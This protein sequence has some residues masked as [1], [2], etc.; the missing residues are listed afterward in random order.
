MVFQY[1]YYKRI[2]PNRL[3][4]AN[5]QGN[6]IGIL[7]GIKEF[8]LK[9]NVNSIDEISFKIYE[10][11]DGIRNNLYDKLEQMRQIKVQNIAI[12]QIKEINEVNN[13]NNGYKEIIC[14][15]LENELVGKYIDAIDG[16]YSLYDTSDQEY[17]I[18]HIVAKNCSW[19]IG[20]VSASLLLKYRTFSVDS[21]KIYN[22]LTSECSESFGC[23]FQFDTWNKVIN[24]ITLEELGE[25]TDIIISDKNILK[26]YV[27]KSNLDKIITSMRVRGGTNSDG[28][29]FD[30]RSVNPDGSSTLINVNYYKTT[31]W[32]SQSLIDALNVY[33]TAYDNYANQ[34]TTALNT[35]K[36]YQSDL[37]ILQTQLT[38]INSQISAQEQITGVSIKLHYGRP[39][40]NGESDY[41]TYI[42][43]INSISTLATQKVANETEIANKRNQILAI[44][45][46]LDNIGVSLDKSNYFTS[47]QLKELDGFITMGDEYS[48]ETYSAVDTMTEEEIIQM[49]LDLKTQAELELL[50][51]CRPQY[52]IDTSIS[53]L[54]TIQDN[55]DNIISYESWRDQLVCGN[56][57]SLRL[58]PDY[59]VQVRLMVIEYDFDNFE[60]VN[61]IFSDKN[62]LDDELTQLGE[63]ISQAQSSSK[64]F[65]AN[66]YSLLRAS[67][68]TSDLN[69]FRLGVI[70]ASLNQMKNDEKGEITF[71]EFGLKAKQLLPDGTYG[72]HMMW[73]N[74]FR[75]LFSDNSMQSAN[76]AFGLLSLPDGTQ[77]MGIATDL[78]FGKLIMSENLYIQNPSGTYTINNN[79]FTATSTIG[80]NTYSVGINPSTPSDIINVKV[81]GTKKFYI[82]TVTNE[83]MFNGKLTANAINADMINALNIVATSVKSSWVYAGNIS[84][85]QIT[86]GTL[87]GDRING[88][89]ITGVTISGSTLTS[90]GS[91]HTTTI[92]NGF[93]TTSHITAGGTVITGNSITVQGGGSALTITPTNISYFIS[94]IFRTVTYLNS[95]NYSSYI[96]VPSYTNQLI[97]SNT[98]YGNID[99]QG[100]DNAA[101]VNWVQA[102]YQPI[103][104]S[105]VRLKYDI[106]SLDDIPDDLFFNLKPKRFKYKTEMYGKGI[107]F[108]LIAQ[109]VENAFLSF[110]LN[111]YD[112]DIIDIKDVRQYTDDGFYIDGETHRINYNNLISWIIRIVQKQ[113][114]KI[115]QLENNIK[116]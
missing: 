106:H 16:V 11:E 115:I 101:G 20:N 60:N 94:D 2:N 86:A 47:A 52:Q 83:L 33:Q 66:Y 19:T 85:N 6:E 104:T 31:E 90:V 96:S 5:P 30:L 103:G 67:K 27:I 76:T 111:P 77:R 58:R 15:S 98:G 4:L 102:N 38:D 40:V 3:V 46:T 48:D 73:L 42:N 105:D 110:G 63:I 21:A 116:Q 17:S 95:S 113:Q 26:E 50:K 114:E 43:A 51:V 70:N 18:L 88:G 22:F 54:W 14:K 99:F 82:D 92:S 44:Q 109:E 80:S 91:T 37:L 59:V 56:L 97:A 87:S 93:I 108:G 13:E 53:N 78:I 65:S 84:A 32:M 107:N 79:G 72:N 41:T 24:V 35:Y 69:A 49:K 34:Y 61:L 7:A 8:K 23:I 68:S 29:I 100:F 62:K 64:S 9:Q 75:M 57:I 89:T 112:Y 28:T 36:Q 71:D 39:P 25:L 45:N 81:N 74:P 10:Y 55:K 12:F 1:D